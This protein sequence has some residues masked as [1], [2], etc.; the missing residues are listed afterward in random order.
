MYRSCLRSH[1]VHHLK[2]LEWETSLAAVKGQVQQLKQQ[3][4]QLNPGLGEESQPAGAAVGE[5][6]GI[7]L[8]QQQVGGK[9]SPSPPVVETGSGKGS[10]VC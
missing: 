10:M 8:R 5:E 1:Q 2:I 7:G 4:Q 9:R 3:Q 6:D